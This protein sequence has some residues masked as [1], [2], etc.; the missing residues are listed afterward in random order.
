MKCQTHTLIFITRDLL[1]DEKLKKKLDNNVNDYWNKTNNSKPIIKLSLDFKMYFKH[2]FESLS[3][4][5]ALM[6]GNIYP[7]VAWNHNL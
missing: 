6:D 2:Y 7:K 5:C 1:K 4:S 3:E